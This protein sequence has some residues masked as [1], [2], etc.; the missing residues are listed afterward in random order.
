MF[1]FFLLGFSL[2]S[3]VTRTHSHFN[4]Q[5]QKKQQQ[6]QQMDQWKAKDRTRG[7]QSLAKWLRVSDLSPGIAE[8]SLKGK[9]MFLR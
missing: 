8:E 1:F 2:H 3:A 6:Q 7:S 9:Q 4:E 5:W